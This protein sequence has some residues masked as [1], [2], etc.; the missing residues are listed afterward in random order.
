MT[1]EEFKKKYQEWDDSMDGTYE[2]ES[3]DLAQYYYKR[4]EV[5]FLRSI[6]DQL[7][8]EKEKSNVQIL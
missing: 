3:E 2:D 6:I 5:N 4:D 8:D 1:R 7:F